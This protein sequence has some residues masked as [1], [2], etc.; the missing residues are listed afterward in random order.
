MTMT[1][2]ERIERFENAYNRID[3]HLNLMLDE[4]DRYDRRRP[5]AKKVRDASHRMRRLGRHKDFL[6]EIGEL[7]N[8]LVHNRTGDELYL[9]TPSEETVVTLENVERLITAP[10]QVLPRFQGP[11]ARLS[12]EDTLETAWEKVRDTGYSRFPV[13][14]D[15]EFAGLI[16]S[17][18][19]ARWCASKVRDGRLEVDLTSTTVQDVLTIETHRNNAAFLPRTALIDDAE[20]LFA[21]RHGA[22]DAVLITEHGRPD[23]TPL[24][25]ICPADIAGLDD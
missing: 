6:L 11:V 7:R 20:V 17:H 5:F 18:G 16:T 2:Q 15:G 13:Y 10:E 19:F 22:L 12:C 21:K 3:R 14:D 23:Q 9:A 1:E 4:N 8:A 24:G 25:M